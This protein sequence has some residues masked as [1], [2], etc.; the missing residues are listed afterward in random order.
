MKDKS[1]LKK[2]EWLLNIGNYKQAITLFEQLKEDCD[3]CEKK[4]EIEIKIDDCSNNHAKILELSAGEAFF[5]VFDEATGLSV[6]LTLQITSSPGNTKVLNIENVKKCVFRY[7]DKYLFDEVKNIM[8]FDWGDFKNLKAEIKEIPHTNKEFENFIMNIDGKSYELA[9][10]VALISKMLNVK[11]SSKYIFSGIINLESDNLKISKVEKVN[12]KL[13]GIKIER[14]DTE[15]FFTPEKSD[16]KII[17]PSTDFKKVSDIVFTNFNTLND[18]IINNETIMKITLS[19]SDA[20]TEDFIK[21]KL[22]KF[23]QPDSINDDEGLQ[24]NEIF[25]FFKNNVNHFKGTIEGI[26]IDGLK[27]N[28]LTPMLIAIKDITNHVSN[29]LAVTKTGSKK[30]NFAKAIVVRSSNSNPTR[31]EGDIFYYKEIE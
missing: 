26:V 10:A 19:I 23:K 24:V 16:D 6:F 18:I 2:A 4:N 12:D 29:Y 21:T 9:A 30:E 8:V 1:E 20:E 14:P 17:N 13:F 31:K 7:M 3:D 28:Y 25:K 22:F 27:V 11:I 5:P 15:I